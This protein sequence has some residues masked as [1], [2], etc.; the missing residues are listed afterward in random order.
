MYP[1]MMRKGKKLVRLKFA[2]RDQ[3][4]LTLTC[5]LQGC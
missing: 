2:H 3:Y 5:D 4:G 1:Y